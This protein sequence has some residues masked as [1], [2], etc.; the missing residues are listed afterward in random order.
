MS[1][2]VY[3]ETHPWISFDPIRLPNDHELWFLLGEARS[4]IE[5]LQGAPLEPDVSGELNRVYLAK[6][7]WATTAI[8][9]NTLNEDQALAAVEG[10]LDLPPSQEYLGVEI[11]NAVDAMNEVKDDLV[12]NGAREVTPGLIRD[13]NRRVL[14]GLEVDDGVVPGEYRTDS[15]VVGP[16]KSPPAENVEYLVDELCHWLRTAFDN[17]G[18]TK[19][20]ALVYSVVKAIAAHVYFE[21]IHPFG[22]GNGRTGR[23][24]EYEILLCGGV[25]LPAAVLLTTHYNITRNDYYRQLDRASKSGGDLIPFIRYALRGFV[26]GLRSQIDRVRAQQMDVMFENFVHRSIH[27]TSP[28]NERHR[29]LVLELAKEEGPVPRV[30]LAKFSPEVVDL[31]A[32]KGS[33]TLSRDLNYLEGIGMIKREGRGYVASKDMMLAFLPLRIR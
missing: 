8:E 17:P 26:D 3:E 10:T 6:G 7:A 22:D 16:Y 25:P 4:K 20:Y 23:L 15:R 12:R 18:A 21:W 27:G 5:H 11:Q 31:Y 2:R 14:K 13:W 19:E 33:K 9:G 1:V 30:H 29:T 28:R 24:I 32:G